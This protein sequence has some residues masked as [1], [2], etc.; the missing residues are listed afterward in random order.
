MFP[1][2]VLGSGI[3]MDSRAIATSYEVIRLSGSHIKSVLI[4]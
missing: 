4:R 2:E 3:R 1:K